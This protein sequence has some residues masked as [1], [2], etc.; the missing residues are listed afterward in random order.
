MRLCRQNRCINSSVGCHLT[1][2]FL[3]IH[4]DS[5]RMQ[6]FVKL[7]EFWFFCNNLLL[8]IVNTIFWEYCNLSDRQYP[9][10]SSYHVENFPFCWLMFSF[11]VLYVLAKISKSFFTMLRYLGKYVYST[12]SITEGGNECLDGSNSFVKN[13]KEEYNMDWLFAVFRALSPFYT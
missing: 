12:M 13:Q 11:N 9:K 2:G 8:V 3:C 10:F 1:L 5:Y 4:D 6:I 7:L